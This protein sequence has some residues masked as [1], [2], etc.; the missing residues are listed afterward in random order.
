M[1]ISPQMTHPKNSK[2]TES[3]TNTKLSQLPK[4][5]IKKMGKKYRIGVKVKPD[6]LLQL[7]K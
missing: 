3:N 2:P 7:T 4:T 5:T 6:Y 1:M